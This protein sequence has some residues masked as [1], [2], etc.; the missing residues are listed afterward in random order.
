MI[1]AVLFDVG[2]TL[3]TVENND[4]LRT[5]FAERLSKRL[6]DC[7]IFLNTPYAEL[8]QLLHKN[9]EEYKHICEESKTEWP[10]LKIW[11]DYYLKDFDIPEEKLSPI[12]EELSFHYTYD[13]EILTK[14]PNLNKCFDELA[15]MGQRLGVISN[16]ISTTSVPTLLK[17]YGIDRYMEIV[18]LSS[19]TT[20]RKPDPGMF[21]IA[22]EKMGLK[23]EEI[24][25]VGDTISR[26]VLGSRNAG[27]GLCIQITNKVADHR[28]AAFH[29]K[30]A[31]KPDYLIQDLS[32]I[33]D[34]IRK[35]NNI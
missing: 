26:D 34:I 27:L 12:A 21:F 20:I 23:A 7:G 16:V 6:E 2:G 14:R 17:E 29:G 24:A 15:A 35:V 11:K 25:Y 13:R 22:M 10:S 5:A 32:E 8:G 4:D 3:L 31:P 9:A 28:D 1:K 19:E 30:D 18:L 33:P